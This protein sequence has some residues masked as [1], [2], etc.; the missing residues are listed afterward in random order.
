MYIHALMNMKV[1]S[2]DLIWEENDFPNVTDNIFRY[3][4]LRFSCF[5]FH[6]RKLIMGKSNNSWLITN[7]KSVE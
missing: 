1:Y 2:A 7:Q 3:V 6:N 4:A 5:H